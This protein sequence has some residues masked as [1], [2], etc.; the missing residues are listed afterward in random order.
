MKKIAL[1][2]ERKISGEVNGGSIRD[3][4]LLSCLHEFSNVDVFYNDVSNCGR[5]GVFKCNKKLPQKIINAL[6]SEVY[7][8]VIISTFTVSP[9]YL[10]YAKINSNAIYYLCDSAFHMLSQHLS[11]KVK[12]ITLFLC[13]KE[14]LSLRMVCAAYLGDDEIKRLPSK[15]KSKGLVFPFFIEKK[16]SLFDKNGFVTFV[17]DYSF[18]PNRKA[19]DKIILLAPEVNCQFKLFGGNFPEHLRL[20]PNVVYEGYV[21]N[22]SDLY[23]GARALIYPIEYGTGVKNKVI[24]AMS[25]G[26]PVIGYKQAFTNFKLP[27]NLKSSVVEKDSDFK[28]LLNKD[29]S[30]LAD[31]SSDFITNEFSKDLVVNKISSI[32]RVRSKK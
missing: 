3:E 11:Y 21:D 2:T 18:L 32:L 28:Y 4:R 15:L 7:D 30:Y 13:I 24:E 22:L 14:W 31:A 20:P 1:I 27:I 17:G 9:Y 26:I 16:E 10:S 12:L 29:L 19:L 5:L 23:H 6:N 8:H 25:Y